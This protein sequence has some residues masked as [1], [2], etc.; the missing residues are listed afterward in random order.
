MSGK[1][2]IA[3]TGKDNGKAVTPTADTKTANTNSAPGATPEPTAQTTQQPPNPEPQKG[4]AKTIPEIIAKSEKLNQLISGLKKLDE[5]YKELDSIV[6]GNPKVKNKLVI[7]NI[8]GD[9]FETSNDALIEDTVKYLKER[10]ETRIE[11][12]SKELADQESQY[13]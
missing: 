4:K 10:I 3:L 13:A 8:S 7:E 12:M 2:S 11:V 5:A 6:V 1:N 9:D